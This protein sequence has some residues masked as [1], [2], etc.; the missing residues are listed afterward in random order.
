MSSVWTI[1]CEWD[2]GHEGTV[3]KTEQ[4]ARDW[5]KKALIWSDV[6]EPIE[7]LE[8]QGLIHFNEEVILE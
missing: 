1:Y 4:A 6:E 7:E 2:I 8:P 5:A 3:F